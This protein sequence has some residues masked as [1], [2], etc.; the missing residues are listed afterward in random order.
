MVALA[1]AQFF[2]IELF[3]R[4][5]ERV[6]GVVGS[7]AVTKHALTLISAA[8]VAVAST[9][10]LVP[11]DGTPSRL[12][13]R[14]PWMGLIAALTVSITPWIVDPP[15]RL[16]TALATRAE[17]FDGTWR[18]AVHWA[19]YLTY[20]GWALALATRACWR[21]R[22]AA[23]ESAARKAFTYVGVGTA[24]S[25]TYV[26]EKAVIVAAWLGGHGSAVV[27]FDEASEVG[28]CLVGLPLIALGCSYEPLSARLAEIRRQAEFRRA[29][30]E[31]TPFAEQAYQVFPYMRTSFAS[32]QP[33][34][35]LVAAVAAIHEALRQLTCYHP[36][37]SLSHLASSERAL[38]R[39]TWL[40]QALAV[41]NLGR[42]PTLEV[43][44]APVDD[45]GSSLDSARALAALYALAQAYV[46]A[47]RVP[48]ISTPTKDTDDAEL[49]PA[50]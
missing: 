13:R 25:L 36:A 30:R 42:A 44:A 46:L 27:V 1:A 37:P 47:G 39:A 43:R 50:A 15:H 32:S 41:K 2:Q 40:V 34:E 24:V 6:T 21:F 45:A 48:A 11:H 33:D 49:Q 16:S 28:I 29:V 8:S 20:L 17:Y 4:E 3:Y 35:Q 23:S 9:E 26:I 18:S 19:A 38:Q 31:I 14:V 5:F 7:G 22:S 10:A 12:R